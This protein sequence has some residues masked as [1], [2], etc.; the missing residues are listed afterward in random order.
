MFEV[1]IDFDEA[2]HAWRANKK[3]KHGTYYNYKCQN[4]NSKGKKC[5][6]LANVSNIFVNGFYCKFHCKAKN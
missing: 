6:N 3:C 1:N 2:S 5:K 4:I